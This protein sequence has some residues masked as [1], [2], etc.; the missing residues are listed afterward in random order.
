M[1]RSQQHVGTIDGSQGHLR[2][3][4]TAALRLK[5]RRNCLHVPPLQLIK[6][7]RIKGELFDGATMLD[8]DEQL[9]RDTGCS[10]TVARKI[11]HLLKA[12]QQQ[13]CC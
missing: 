3:A 1:I 10:I 2:L 7:W 5:S 8:A 11:L 9:L 4:G 12:E 13:V 6:T